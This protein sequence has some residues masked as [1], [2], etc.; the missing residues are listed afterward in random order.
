MDN[1]VSRRPVWESGH[2]PRRAAGFAV[3]VGFA[4]IGASLQLEQENAR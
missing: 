2:L 1:T 4:P 3:G